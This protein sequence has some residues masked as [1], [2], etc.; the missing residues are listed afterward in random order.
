M[1]EGH[2]DAVCYRTR[3]SAV[4][5]LFRCK[6]N[7]YITKCSQLN[8]VSVT[9]GE[10]GEAPEQPYSENGGMF[11]TANTESTFILS[12]VD[13]TY[14]EDSEF[15]LKCTGNANQR[16]WETTALFR[17]RATGNIPL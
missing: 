3:L 6:V 2:F 7:S 10:N 9:E 13:I 8:I 1:P 11:Y 16:G 12:D 4:R 5:L 15:L 14:A 17:R